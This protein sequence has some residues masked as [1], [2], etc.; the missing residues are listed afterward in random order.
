M[1]AHGTNPED[2]LLHPR[3][4]SLFGGL[5][6][7][8]LLRPAFLALVAIL[9]LPNPAL[10]QTG[11]L[12]DDAYTS[13]NALVQSGNLS[14]SGPAIVVA[15]PNATIAGRAAGPAT[16]MSNSNSRQTYRQAQRSECR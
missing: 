12:T 4:G 14:G 1:K 6:I 2:Q 7:G 13:T 16:A 10:A 9:A 3:D 11:T 15:G 5:R 8:S